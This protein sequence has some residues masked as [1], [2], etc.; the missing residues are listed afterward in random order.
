MDIKYSN[1]QP[2]IYLPNPL[3]RPRLNLSRPLIRGWK[4]PTEELTCVEHECHHTVPLDLTTIREGGSVHLCSSFSTPSAPFLTE[5]DYSGE[6]LG[7]YLLLFHLRPD[8]SN[9]NLNWERIVGEVVMPVQLS[10]CITKEW[11]LV[12]TSFDMVISLILFA[13][14]HSTGGMRVTKPAV[15]I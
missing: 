14:A 13:K 8:L 1:K 10:L 6:E 3:L 7:P 15:L 5:S 9:Q 4:A 11:S 2:G 12:P